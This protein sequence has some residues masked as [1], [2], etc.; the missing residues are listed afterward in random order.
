VSQ[1]LSEAGNGA[2]WMTRRVQGA[3]PPSSFLWRRLR[4]G[5]GE[6]YC[7]RRVYSWRPRFRLPPLC[8]RQARPT[9][10]RTGCP[11]PPER[12]GPGTSRSE[13]GHPV[14]RGAWIP[15]RRG[16]FTVWLGLFLRNLTTVCPLGRI[17]VVS[18]EHRPMAVQARTGQCPRTHGRREQ[19]VGGSPNQR[20]SSQTHG[21]VVRS[22]TATQGIRT[23]YAVSSP[24]YRDSRPGSGSG[25]LL[26]RQVLRRDRLPRQARRQPER[27]RPRIDASLTPG[28]Q[29]ALPGTYPQVGVRTFSGVRAKERKRKSPDEWEF[30]SALAIDD[31][32]REAPCGPHSPCAAS[33]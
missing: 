5:K 8:P 22:I 12:T 18:V 30:H 2:T 3:A 20:G 1:S 25:H 27:P 21:A 7:R 31:T 19:R 32:V 23:S 14:S 16:Y 11:G 24:K 28:P 4:L 17:Q 10:P 29:C 9:S 33:A 6:G 15:P 26:W 13:G